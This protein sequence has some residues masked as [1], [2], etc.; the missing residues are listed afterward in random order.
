[1]F[2]SALRQT[3]G[4]I[5]S[6]LA[7]LGLALAVTDHSPLSRVDADTG[8]ILAAVLTTNDVDD[9]SQVSTLLDQAAPL[10]SFTADGAYDQDGVYG[11]VAKRSPKQP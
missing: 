7:L 9:A 6:I 10:A 8:R 5:S 11:E 4:L 2:R 3:E 1:M